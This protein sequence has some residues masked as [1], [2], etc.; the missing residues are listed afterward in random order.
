LVFQIDA[1]RA[2]FSP[3]CG[4]Y[5]LVLQVAGTD[6]V[7]GTGHD[8]LGGEDAILDQAADPVMS[9]ASHDGECRLR[10]ATAMLAAL[11]FADPQLRMLA[12]APMDRQDDLARRLVDI[13]MISVTRARRSR[14]RVRMVTPGALHAASRSSARPAKS[15]GTAAR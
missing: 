11:G 2:T 5:S 8:L 13:G 1:T 10:G 6:L 9:H 12:A 7:R 14:W 4:G 15:G 3:E